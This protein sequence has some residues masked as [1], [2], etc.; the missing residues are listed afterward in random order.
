MPAAAF[1]PIRRCRRPPPSPTDHQHSTALDIPPPPCSKAYVCPRWPNNH[2][3][4]CCPVDV[5]LVPLKPAARTA[6]AGSAA[7]LAASGKKL[8]LRASPSTTPAGQQQAEEPASPCS[9]ELYARW[10][11]SPLQTH[12]RL[13]PAPSLRMPAPHDMPEP[14]LLVS[15]RCPLTALLMLQAWS[16]T[17]T[18]WRWSRARHQARRCAR[19]AC[20]VQWL[21]GWPGCTDLLAELP[22]SVAFARS[23]T[24]AYSDLPLVDSQLPQLALLPSSHSYPASGTVQ[25]QLSG[26]PAAPRASASAAQPGACV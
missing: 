5:A 23:L 25:E 9:G 14:L 8:K 24:A 21:P 7:V 17:A 26:D 12:A 22:Q 18:A 4:S 20:Q 15:T 6:H 19:P 11:H 3:S 1:P 13:K 16:A 2:C 10:Q